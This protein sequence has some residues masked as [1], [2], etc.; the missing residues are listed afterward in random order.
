ML[1]DADWQLR[2]RIYTSF[3]ETGAPPDATQLD[4]AALRRLHEA[5]AIVL[6][7]RGSIRM[8]LPFSAVPTGHVVRAG[9]ASWNANCAWDALAIPLLLGIDAEIDS[10]WLD[11]S[12]SVE[13]TVEGGELNSTDGLVYFGIPARNWWDDIVET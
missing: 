1:S 11:G 6:D 5:H 10:Q 3:V 9:T 12:G 8:A 13:L 2:H 7:E 4:A